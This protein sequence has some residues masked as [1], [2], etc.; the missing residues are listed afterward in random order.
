VTA[1]IIGARTME[2]LNDNLGAAG[3]SL[4]AE[5][6]ERLNQASDLPLPYPYSEIVGAQRRR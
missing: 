6:M 3:W 4:S 2:Q 5:H 1:P